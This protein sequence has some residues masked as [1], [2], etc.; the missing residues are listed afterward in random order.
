MIG[1]R[2]AAACGGQ[3]EQGQTYCAKVLHRSVSNA[4]EP[5]D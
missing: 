3:S 1:I 5:V 2:A 4:D